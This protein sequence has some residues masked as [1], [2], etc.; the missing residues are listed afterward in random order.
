MSSHFFNNK[1]ILRIGLISLFCGVALTSC[2]KIID[3]TPP[4]TIYRN[5]LVGV[6]N[7]DSLI[8]VQVF[9]TLPNTVSEN[10]YKGMNGLGV[11][12]TESNGNKLKMDDAG[13][14]I[15]V[16]NQKPKVGTLYTI[17]AII[18]DNITLQAQDSVPTLEVPL[19]KL[20]DPKSENF[21]S[22]PD[23]IISKPVS[24]NA[25]WWFSF[26][27]IKGADNSPQSLLSNS[28]YLDIFNS[29]ID[30]IDGRRRYRYIVRVLPNMP[31]K[32]EI[33]LG[34][35]NSI[36]DTD[37]A[38]VYLSALSPSYDKYLKTAIIAQQRSISDKDGNLK[39]PFGDFFSTYSNVKNGLG[40]FVGQNSKKLYLK[41]GR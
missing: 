40:I 36:K 1:K 14:G 25:N 34:F 37:S 2:V 23:L 28:S 3:L 31:D 29:R 35:V 41:K 7:P 33:E 22:N 38:Y 30:N 24:T 21:N 6:L 39:N 11:Y 9:E 27:F 17:E 20:T 10:N 12:M 4:A 19:V 32:A 15:Y 13:N 8:K 26:N 16:L 18:N 5:V